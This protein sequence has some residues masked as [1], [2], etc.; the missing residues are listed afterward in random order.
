MAV[1]LTTPKTLLGAFA[2]ATGSARL[3]SG[4]ATIVLGTLFITLCSKINVPTWPI[5]VTLQTLSVAVLAAAFGARIGVATVLLYLVEG[6][7]GLPVFSVGGGPLY[8]LSPAFGFI[9]GFIPM[10]YIIG[11]AADAGLSRNALQLLA[12]SLLGDA[13]CFAIGYLWLA[14]YLGNA[15]GAGFAGVLSPAFTKGV[16]PF[17]VWDILK[18]AFAAVSVSGAWMLVR[19]KR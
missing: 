8:A 17:L 4:L 15:T 19:P 10:A 1:T 9:L 18:M 7:S 11:R 5:S 14:V 12:V 6:L 3:A 13:V 16:Q 2:P